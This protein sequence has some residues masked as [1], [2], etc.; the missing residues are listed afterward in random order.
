[1]RVCMLST[2]NQ[3]RATGLCSSG[4]FNGISGSARAIASVCVTLYYDT[5]GMQ[6]FCSHGIAKVCDRPQLQ[7][8]YIRAHLAEL[9]CSVSVICGYIPLKYPDDIVE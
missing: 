6:L 2:T 8:R 9:Y 7:I 3:T 1:M 5:Y 4:Y